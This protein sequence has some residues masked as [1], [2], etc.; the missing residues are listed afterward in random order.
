[1]NKIKLS[2]R[3]QVISDFINNGERVADIGTDHGYIPIYLLNE[4]ISE[5][6]ILV[7]INKGPLD[8][9]RVNLNE[10]DI[11]PN[12]YKLRLGN[13]LETIDNNEVDAVVIAG[14]GGIL[15]SEI[16]GKDIEKS[17]SLKKFI[18][19]PRNFSA[20]LRNWLI[21]NGF[22]IIDEKLAKESRFVCEVIV[23]VPGGKE[24]YSEIELEIGKRVIEKKDPL[25]EP[26]LKRLIYIEE[27]INMQTKAQ[28]TKK[29]VNQNQE[30]QK[31]IER[32]K[33]ELKNVN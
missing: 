15:I 24:D 8:I 26:F 18:L 29:S 32:L 6:V 22:K 13:G 30:S 2:E 20:H 12:S 4:E 7:D 3:L 11:D 28:G 17:Y 25:L 23:A 1:M 9:A 14:M 5:N 31:R 10:Y 16:I 19:Q 33:E 27:K 21:N